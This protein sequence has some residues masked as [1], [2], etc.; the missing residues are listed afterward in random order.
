MS[1]AVLELEGAPRPLVL[2]QPRTLSEHHR[3]EWLL[4][5]KDPFEPF[6]HHLAND[7]L[8]RQWNGS[9]PIHLALDSPRQDIEHAQLDT[10]RHHIH[11][12]GGRTFMAAV[13]P[14]FFTVRFRPWLSVTVAAS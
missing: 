1:V 4:Q 8:M 5:R 11:H 3:D 14:W 12:L 2:H 10:D 6:C 9:W 13:S 7:Y